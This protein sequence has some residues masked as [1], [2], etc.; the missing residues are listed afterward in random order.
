MTWQSV[1]LLSPVIF[2]AL[3][4]IMIGIF[5]NSCQKVRNSIAL[6]SSSLAL[7][8][9]ASVFA[10][11]LRGVDLRHTYLGLLGQGLSFTSTGLGSG[12]AL[13]AAF[14][15]LLAVVFAVAYMEHEHSASRFFA[16]LLIT[17]AGCLGVF[18]SG[19]YF[20][21]F[22][23]FEVMTFAAY[24]LIIH[25]EDKSAMSAGNLY[26]YLSVAGGLI[27]LFGIIALVWMSGTAQI[28]PVMERFVE[29]P[30]L[31][32]WVAGTF[33]VGFGVKAGLVPLHIW[34]PQ[35]HPVAPSPA[36]ALLSG[37]MI[38][39]GAYGIIRFLTVSMTS[40]AG[41]EAM[42]SLA[43]I[44]QTIGII[45]VAVAI[46][47]MLAGA[48]MALMQTSMKKI[49]AYS[50]V[51]QM[52]YIILPLGLAVYLGKGLG[53]LA[54][55]GSVF[56]LF[57]HAIFKSG[58]FMMFGAV[59]MLTHTLDFDKLGGM[60]KVLP[61][62][63]AVALIGSLA[64]LG[65]PGFSGFASKTL[66]HDAL[67]VGAEETQ[68]WWI[69][70][71]EKMFVLGSALTA[72]YFIKLYS[73]VFLGKYKGKHPI[74]GR[75]HTLV[76]VVTGVYA[77]AILAVGVLP[78]WFTK[79]VGRV[80]AEGIPWLEYH[81][82]EH[83]DHIH[84]WDSHAYWGVVMPALLGIG[85]FFLT[86]KLR[87]EDWKPPVWLSVEYLIYRP[88]SQGFLYICSRYVCGLEGGIADVYETSSTVSGS[89]IRRVRRIDSMID[90][91]YDQ[92]S[93]VS[94]ELI[95]RVRQID[96][97]IGE[98]YDQGQEASGHLVDRVRRAADDDIEEARQDGSAS[99]DI[100]RAVREV[101]ELFDHGVEP[102][103]ATSRR[104]IRKIRSGKEVLASLDES[105]DHDAVLESPES[106]KSDVLV[107]QQSGIE[108]QSKDSEP[109]K[110]TPTMDQAWCPQNITLG[111]LILA[112]VLMIILFILY[113]F[114]G[115]AL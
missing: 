102:T 93:Q 84:F 37:I 40:G 103:G 99:E 87:F 78:Y 62:T 79:F 32:Y 59:Y 69:N 63:A 75:E 113:F 28:V 29:N 5:R 24:P 98:G 105:I 9:A 68:L 18:L 82:L 46:V 26:L 88:I 10:L 108:D 4:G 57:N 50:S 27:L 15:W 92:G 95:R 11:W 104:L 41:A 89:L 22:L 65:M 86:E 3:G 94:T 58:L 25:N 48:V 39:T 17:Q 21:L 80:S 55:V 111:S 110:Q 70:I 115:A 60:R 66:I 101:E 85:I 64:V 90:D 33:I 44:P 35:A 2:P 7:L 19:D 53:G 42:S 74:K 34:L 77:V 38:K 97:M 52:G 49:L 76:R 30:A 73:R 112:V 107:Q 91:G 1:M 47:T 109:H 81:L 12:I 23:F 71:A 45:L 54:Y 96:D 16:F 14:V 36:S 6:V 114:G 20:T 43:G 100:A 83:L 31:L 67:L 8:S 72:A 13:I 61:F 56:H 51:S 106:D